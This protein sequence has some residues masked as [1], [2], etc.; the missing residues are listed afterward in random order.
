MNRETTSTI[1]SILKMA[2]HNM[3]AKES[4]CL[5]Y[6]QELGELVEDIDSYSDT[7][8]LRSATTLFE[9]FMRDL[10]VAK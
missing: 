9:E 3:E 2:R 4:I 5:H 6:L 7:H 1:G 8:A 10:G